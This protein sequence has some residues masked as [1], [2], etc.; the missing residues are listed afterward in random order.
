MQCEMLQGHAAHRHGLMS[1]R[2][3]A[4][5]ISMLATQ[6]SIE[7][8][9]RNYSP[10]NESPDMP[11]APVSEIHTP[12]SVSEAEASPHADI[13]RHSMD[14]ELHGLLLAGTFAPV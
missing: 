2:D 14:R 4:A 9:I 7:D 6:E 13:W 1:T 11:T 10:P 8:A 3:H 12:T 5:L